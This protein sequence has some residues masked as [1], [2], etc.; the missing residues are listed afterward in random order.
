[1]T[2][3]TLGF[4]G[5]GNLAKRLYSGFKTIIDQKTTPI[6]YSELNQLPDSFSDLK[7]VSLTELLNKSDIIFLAV[8]PHQLIELK[9]T[10]THVDWSKKCLVSL[11]AGKTIS[12]IKNNIPSIQHLIRVMPN[13]C[14]EF[15]QSMT[16]YS[17]LKLTD[18]HYVDYIDYLFNSVGSCIQISDDNMNLC[19]ALSWQHIVW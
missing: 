13:T 2:H 17:V 15:K 19:T 16:V 5:F 8:K 6:Y 9:N 14:A 7:F 3:F 18:S 11:L 4:I 1:M 12:K 10:L